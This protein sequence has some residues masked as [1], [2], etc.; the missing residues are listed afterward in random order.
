MGTNTP[1]LSYYLPDGGE[2]GYGDE[3]NSDWQDLDGR[4]QN[5]PADGTHG[6][7]AHGPDYVKQTELSYFSGSHDDLTNVSPNDHHVAPYSVAASGSLTLSAGGGSVDTGVATDSGHY[8][9]NLNPGSA[10]VA[11]S[12][13]GSGANYVIHFEENTTAV[14]TPT[15][16]YQLMESEI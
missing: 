16:A 2:N 6:D 9:V 14:G 1:N 3:K 13:D 5:L 8:T 11:M 12:L 4:L 15:V 7:A 10:D